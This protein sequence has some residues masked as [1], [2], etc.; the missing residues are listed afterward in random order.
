MDN[1]LKAIVTGAASFAATNIDDIFVLMLFFGQKNRSVKV[2]HIVAGQY[3]GF[4]ALVAISL[5]G[6]FARYLVPREWIGFLGILPI[7]IGVKKLIE[8]R[9]AK[10]DVPHKAPQRS[11]PLKATSSVLTV[12]AV[13][14]AN[15]ADN[16]GIYTPLF[17][18]IGLRQ[19]LITL[20]IFS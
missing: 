13:T 16:I 12:S 11:D 20:A 18:A 15:G 14:F 9:K 7:A 19:L 10:S 2:W 1:L 8:W 17:A 5:V 6:H 3:V 4:A